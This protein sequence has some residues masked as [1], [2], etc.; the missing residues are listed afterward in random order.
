MQYILGAYSQLPFGSSSEEY[1]ALLAT[2]LKPLLTFLYQNSNFKLLFHLSASEYE[3]YEAN[4]PE[5]NMLICDL[6]R[7]GQMEIL[8]SGYYDVVLSLLPAHERSAHVEKT[9]TY[10]RK[11]FSKKP[12]GLWCYNQIFTPS[13]I[14]MLSVSGL[15][16][17]LISTY[18]QMVNSQLMTKPFY[19]DEMGK[20]ALVIPFDDRFAK[21][22]QDFAKGNSSLEKYLSNMEK[23][24]L[25]VTGLVSTI[26]INMDQLASYAGSFDV[27]PLLYS[28]LGSNSTLPSLFLSQNEVKRSFYLPSGVYGRDISVG[29]A[30]SINQYIIENPVLY[31]NLGILNLLRE[32][33]RECKKNT[34]E[35]KNMEKLFL[36][37]SSCGLYIPEQGM[38]PAIRRVSNKSL[39]EIE[40]I[41]SKSQG[42]LMP[43]MAYLDSARHGEYIIAGKTAVC[44]LNTKGAIL[45]RLNVTL[46]SYDI[47][48]H[49]GEGLF[50]DS[51]FDISTN[52]ETKLSSK[53]YE[54]TPLD[55]RKVDFFAKAPAIELKKIPINLTK[56]YKFRQSTIMVEIEIENL[57][58]SK[59]LEGLDYCCSLGFA[60]PKISN[61]KIS[62]GSLVETN[63][64]FTNMVSVSDKS[65]PFVL[66]VALSCDA[67]VSSTNYEQKIKTCLGDKAVYEYTQLKIKKRLSLEP[68]EDVR[69]TIGLRIEKRKEK[70]NDLTEQSTT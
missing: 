54:V 59:K 49:S 4:H 5:I 52:K 28:K 55:K 8:S 38:S 17:I 51:F 7:K 45:S 24:S 47:A 21:E 30:L 53:I 66:S 32:A 37:A 60:L 13:L 23:L 34:D 50:G 48:M 1:E 15:D 19:M 16:Y 12:K 61:F 44:Y 25:S 63:P 41:L 10:I 3:Y 33:M 56:R 27:F 46:A 68:L 31:R 35:R 67:L 58:N 57:D 39:C 9:T 62:D 20:T 69:L 42:S 43:Q 22:T 64:V 26:M 18:N 36:K 65:S 11:R 6:C 29:K 40:T 14:P 2:Q 70:N